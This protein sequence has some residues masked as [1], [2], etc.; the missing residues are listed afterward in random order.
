MPSNQRACPD[1]GGLWDARTPGGEPGV[2]TP[3]PNPFHDQ[4]CP[5]PWCERTD[6]HVHD[7]PA[8]PERVESTGDVDPRVPPEQV[9]PAAPRGESPDPFHVTPQWLREQARLANHHAD[10]AR[11][12]GIENVALESDWRGKAAAYGH[13]AFLLEAEEVQHG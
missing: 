4:R 2:L 1:C 7:P 12:E 13:I 9:A 8:Q 11:G 6:E 3:C 5:I 10:Q